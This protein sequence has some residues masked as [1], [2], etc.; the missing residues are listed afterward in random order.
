MSG[1]KACPL[2][3]LYQIKDCVNRRLDEKLINLK[4]LN[5]IIKDDKKGVS[6]VF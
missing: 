4:K 6:N 3:A 5:S 1:Q 2:K